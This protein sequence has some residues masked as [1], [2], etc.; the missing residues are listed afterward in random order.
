M[1]AGD[2][3]YGM[4]QRCCRGNRKEKFAGLG[5]ASKWWRKSPTYSRATL[6]L[7]CRLQNFSPLEP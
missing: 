5:F 4:Y 6:G 1:F 2:A 7:V 3:D